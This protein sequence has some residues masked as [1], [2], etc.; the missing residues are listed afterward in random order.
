MKYRIAMAVLACLSF[1]TEAMAQDAKAAETFLRGIYAG[2]TSSKKDPET[3]GKKLNL[4]FS[5]ELAGLIKAD[6]DLAIGEVGVLDGDPICACQDYDKLK[7]TKVDVT[8]NGPKK[9]QAT[10][11]FENFGKPMTVKYWLESVDGKW[12]VSD[13]SETGLEG[14]RKMLAEGIVTR[15]KELAK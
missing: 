12:R 4:I 13:I 9:A 3:L 11:V 7:V 5:P 8:L 14:L 15:A 6:S 1:A 10:V 2:Y